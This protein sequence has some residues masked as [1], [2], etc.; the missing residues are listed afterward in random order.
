MVVDDADLVDDEAENA[1]GL[2]DEADLDRMLQAVKTSAA[3]KVKRRRQSLRAQ[4]DSKRPLFSSTI[5]NRLGPLPLQLTRWPT[6]SDV[7]KIRG[8]ID[9]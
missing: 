2:E 6:R 4:K 9:I 5:E 8:K 1:E 3:S 7:P